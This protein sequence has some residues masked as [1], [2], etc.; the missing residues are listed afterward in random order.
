MPWNLSHSVMSANLDG[1]ESLLKRHRLFPCWA[2]Q[3]WVTLHH[4]RKKIISSVKYNCCCSNSHN[5]KEEGQDPIL[6]CWQ[7]PVNEGIEKFTGYYILSQTKLLKPLNYRTRQADRKTDWPTHDPSPLVHV[8]IIGQSVC[9]SVCVLRLKAP[10]K[11][12]TSPT[13]KTA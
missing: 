2:A 11:R 6:H 9:L 3:N 10:Y 4:E 12:E 1:H 7:T 13:T 5:K 8:Y